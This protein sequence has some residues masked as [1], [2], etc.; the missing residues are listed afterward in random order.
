MHPVP[1]IHNDSK[2]NLSFLSTP[3]IPRNRKQTIRVDE[4]VLLQTADKVVDIDSIIQTE[5]TWKLQR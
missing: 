4:L 3:T 1:T 2:S 5:F